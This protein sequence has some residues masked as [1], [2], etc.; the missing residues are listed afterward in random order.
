M[1]LVFC[2]ELL[3]VPEQAWISS[4]AG[5][6][7]CGKLK[8]LEFEVDEYCSRELSENT[9]VGAFFSE[10]TCKEC[11]RTFIFRQLYSY[12][13]HAGTTMILCSD[14]TGIG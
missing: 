1:N 14:S 4:P 2:D 5:C 8:T 7:A 6:P 3:D 10:A 9:Y 12:V 11:E 13:S